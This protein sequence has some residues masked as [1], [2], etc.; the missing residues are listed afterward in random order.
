ML[1]AWPDLVRRDKVADFRPM[2]H[3]ME[4]DY[5]HLRADYPAGFGWMTQD[6][7]HSGAVGD[8]TAATAAKGEAALDHGAR[9]FIA[10]L[11]DVARFDPG[12]L[13]PGPLG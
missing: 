7:H 9:A 6:L 5:A 4:R 13:A 1:A 2:T 8:A 3:A 11:D 10:L 12:N